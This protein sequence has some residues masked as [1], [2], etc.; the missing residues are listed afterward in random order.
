MVEVE[1][2]SINIP[3][4]PKFNLSDLKS[5]FSDDIIQKVESFRFEKDQ[6]R[7]LISN[8]LVRY[9]ICEK[10]ELSPSSFRYE[11]SEN[12]KPAVRN[13][14]N[15][16]FNLSHS[17]AWVVC[18]LDTDEIG[19]DIEKKNTIDLEEV[20]YLLDNNEKEFIQAT[21]VKERASLFYSIWTAKESYLKALGYGISGPIS[22]GSLEIQFGSNGIVLFIRKNK[23]DD[24]NLVPLEIDPDYSLTVCTRSKNIKKEVTIID[25]QDII[26]AISH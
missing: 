22:P 15:L 20:N 23:V 21:P 11:V 19:I 7:S 2:F 5:S 24:W 16:H 8:A 3:E 12:G 18:A 1:V 4:E 14:E 17:G 6:L 9:L 10:T 13:S 25:I 26:D